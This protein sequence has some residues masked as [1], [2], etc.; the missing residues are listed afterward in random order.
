V[1]RP[2]FANL[3]AAFQR[4]ILE[5]AAAEFAEH[6]FKHASLNHIIGALGL[7]KGVF[8]YYFDSKADLFAAVVDLVWGLLVPSR[9]LDIA[10]LDA[11]TYWPR[12]EALMEENHA[13]LR[14]HRWLAGFS[15]LLFNVPRGVGIDPAMAGKLAQ[16][17]AWM[18][19]LIRAGQALG[20]VRRD[21]PVALLLASLAAADQAADRWLLDHWQDLDTSDRQRIS[22]QIFNLWRRIAEP[23]RKPGLEA[24]S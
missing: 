16:G 17:H 6:G 1:P 24:A 9:T 14:E 22:R 8:Y 20:V 15:R 23:S 10:S 13:L 7:S 12:I 21:M 3:D 11:E 18:E 4:R 19:A 2:R 5:T